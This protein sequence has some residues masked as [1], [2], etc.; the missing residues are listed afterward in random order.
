MTGP[1][2]ALVV[3]NA[4]RALVA[5]WRARLRCDRRAVQQVLLDPPPELAGYPLVDII[6]LG[7]A[8]RHT[9]SLAQIGRD[10]LAAHVNLLQPVGKASR[11]S[12]KWA[13][14]KGTLGVRHRF[15]PDEVRAAQ[16]MRADG[17]AIAAIA[18]RFGVTPERV[19]HGLRSAA[20]A[21]D[22]S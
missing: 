10:A 20:E 3:G 7:F 4:K 9:H 6:A 19:S 14:E 12:R 17:V 5:E 1:L 15:G 22:D 11:R 21:A 8:S 18:R 16:E 13:A 2:E